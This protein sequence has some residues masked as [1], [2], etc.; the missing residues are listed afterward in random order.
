MV[1]K[2]MLHILTLAIGVVLFMVTTT[3][4][5]G[6][7]EG[8]VTE[9]GS[10][11]SMPGVNVVVQG[12]N[13]G[14]ST[15]ADGEFVIRN[16][17]AGNQ[18][19]EAR[20]IGYKVVRKNVDI[21]S[22]E[23][24]TVNLQLGATSLEMDQV[25]VTGTGGQTRRKEIGNSLEQVSSKQIESAAIS[26]FGDVL[27]GRTAGATIMDNSGQVGAASTIRLRGGNSFSQGNQPLIYID[28]IRVASGTFRGDSEVNQSAAPFDDLNPNDIARVE[29]IK[30]AAATTI[31]GTEASGGVI[32]IFTKQGA[33]GDARWNLSV[34]Q[35]FNNMPKL[36]PDGDPTGLGLWDCEGIDPGCPESGSYHKN[37]HLQRYNLS[38]RGGGQDLSYFISGKLASEDGVFGPQG[39]D[40]YGMRANFGFRPTNSLNLKFNTS[41]TYKKTQ[42]IPDGNNAEGFFLNTLRGDAGY[43]PNNDN[44][45]AFNMELLTRSNHFTSGVTANWTPMENML[46]KVTV[47]IDYSE[48]DYTEERPFGFFYDPKGN[49][50]AD[51][52]KMTN[53]TIDY[54]GS[55]NFDLS[56]IFTSSTSWGAQM[57]D[58]SVIALNAF[59]E[60]FGGPGD[61]LVD[62]AAR[63]SAFENRISTVSGGFFVQERIGYNDRLFITGGLRVDGHSTFGDDFG[64]ALYPKISGS[65]V[66]SDYDFWPEFWNTMKLRA[67]YGESGRAPSAFA[68]LRTWSSVSGD[69]GQPAVTPQNLGNPDLGPERTG[70]FE[71]GFES[72]FINDRVFVEFTYYRQLTTDALVP[73]Q[74]APSSGF[75]N[76]QLENVGKLENK[77]IEAKLNVEVVRNGPVQWSLGGHYSTNKS[78]AL[79]L[80]D[81]DRIYV[82]W[83]QE[84]RTG[85][86][87]PSYFHDR[88][89]NPDA[90][91]EAPEFEDQYIGPSYPTHTYGINTSISFKD[92]LTVNILGEGQGGH[93]LSSGTAYQNVRRGAWPTCTGIQNQ[94]DQGNVLSL[95]AGERARC[96][97][98]ETT[99]GMWTKAADFFKIRSVSVSYQLP[100]SWLPGNIRGATINAQG[101][102]LWT[103]TN[104]P[105]LD[106]EAFEDGARDFVDY[107]QEYYNIPPLR[108]FIMKL[109]VR[110]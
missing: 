90:V 26:D 67:A 104:Y 79:D 39:S 62:S 73:V 68:A 6:I 70:E 23:T 49:R 27:Q 88:V 32:Q 20:F 38:V 59:G 60:E 106:P 29:V 75:V 105:G 64:L 45:L 91:G 22:G 5:Q 98:N 65:F 100:D 99:Y 110:F 31:Y 77:G 96:H 95:S 71:T 51:Y 14:A 109:N 30:G 85:F 19:I 15:N 83:R 58:E 33:E 10:G 21:V 94:I 42:W 74:P 3:L 56:D 34:S 13:I 18:V 52:Y 9:K 48:Q 17:P 28:G 108:T 80:G 46:H 66:P 1:M 61:K 4:G 103:L 101:K 35:G 102:N 92:R 63:T 7:V 8:T 25:V 87:V 54:M 78:E 50:E 69:E 93:V 82:S 24:V 12:T 11:E 97:P 72:S 76:S 47:G 36:G 84:L 44:S 81:V 55:Y 89:T 16:V 43:A 57:Y 41:Y 37:G 53:R 2:R 107:R 86:S 40:N